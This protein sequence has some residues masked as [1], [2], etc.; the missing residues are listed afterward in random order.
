MEKIKISV[1]IPAWNASE[2]LA[3]CAKGLKNQTLDAQLQIILA[4]DG[5]T[6]GTVALADSLG[7]TVIQL[8]HGGAAHARNAAL[9][10]A[11]APFVFF[12]DADDVPSPDAL[13]KLSAPL[14]A[15]Q[16][17]GAVFS[18][19]EDFI[20]SELTEEERSRLQ[21]RPAPYSGVL[22]GCSLIRAEVF[23]KIGSFDESLSS[24]E[25]VAWVMKLRDAGIQT[26]QLE[27]VTLRRRIHRNNT[28]RRDAK[29][30]AANYAAILRA[31]LL[32]NMSAQKAGD[33][34]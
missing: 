34:K 24:G 21:I 13:E 9:T 11:D 3:E 1:I 4:D 18:K 27:D 32:K 5:S 14:L 17:L 26:L 25:T 22:P 10:L 30:E 15:D 12:I 29:G 23:A 19:A 8:N 31:R 28:G 16:Q 2:Y 6:D 20:S 33:T 7:M